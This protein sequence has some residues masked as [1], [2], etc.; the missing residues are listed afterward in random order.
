MIEK[1]IQARPSAEASPDVQQDTFSPESSF[2]SRA[3]DSLIGS[4]A[5]EFL[6]QAQAAGEL[7][8]QLSQPLA[9]QFEGLRDQFETIAEFVD[10]RRTFDLSTGRVTTAEGAGLLSQVI[11]EYGMELREKRE[12]NGIYRSDQSGEYMKV[13]YPSVVVDTAS[14][15][16]QIRNTFGVTVPEI[17]GV[18]L[19]ST[20]PSR[21]S[22]AV[23]MSG[24]ESGFDGR[25]L[26]I[27]SQELYELVKEQY[28]HPIQ[29]YLKQSG[30]FEEL[31]DQNWGLNGTQ[32]LE[33]FSQGIAPAAEDIVI[34]DPVY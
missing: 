11:Q 21:E 30:Y 1:A 19:D 24:V 32:V 9:P 29:D 28:I 7:V 2:A 3:E 20:L 6:N 23:V 22:G 33:R 18:F 34:W 4:I 14:A 27:L 26:K 10:A 8:S 12:K 15:L 31:S 25:T 17:R 16:E 13:G 5:S